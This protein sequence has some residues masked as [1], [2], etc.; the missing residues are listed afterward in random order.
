MSAAVITS[1]IALV[2]T[3]IG[4]YWTSRTSRKLRSLEAEREAE[5]ITSTFR[6][7]LLHAA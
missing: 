5:R 2:G 3:L 6:D 4:G 1:I 7:P